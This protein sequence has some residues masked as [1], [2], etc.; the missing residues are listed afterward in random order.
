MVDVTP[1]SYARARFTLS[2]RAVAPL[3]PFLGSTLRGALGHALRTLS[4]DPGRSLEERALLREVCPFLYVFGEPALDGGGRDATRPYALV[5]PPPQE[6]PWQPGQPLSFNL[7]LFGRAQLYLPWLVAA[8][9]RMAGEGLGADRHA[10]DL[11]AVTSPLDG[12]PLWRG[13]RVVRTAPE[14][15]GDTLTAP[16]PG[17]EVAVRFLTPLRVRPDEVAGGITFERFARWANRRLHAVLHDHCDERPAGGLAP[18][19][20]AARE[21]RAVGQDLLRAPFD[22]YSNRG[23]GR[24]R[25]SVLTGELVFGGPGLSRF[26]PLLRAG[27]VLGVGRSTTMGF[28]RYVLIS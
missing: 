15:T 22:R 12:G 4:G 7:V 28:G 11:V 17:D 14:E 9:R 21:V 23:G 24:Q 13:G 1:L 6:A 26:G 5:P 25:Y 20:A 19:W 2:A 18:V 16:L 3:P 10:F 8:V 27:E